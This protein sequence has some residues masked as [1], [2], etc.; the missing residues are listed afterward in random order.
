MLLKKMFLSDKRQE[1]WLK[2]YI[3]EKLEVNCISIISLF[4]C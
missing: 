4:G 3:Q 2:Q 1:K